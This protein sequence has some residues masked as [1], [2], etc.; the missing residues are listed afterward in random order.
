LVVAGTLGT[1][2]IEC[3][4]S[5]AAAVGAYQGVADAL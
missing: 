4:A 1:A 5:R 2:L 3:E